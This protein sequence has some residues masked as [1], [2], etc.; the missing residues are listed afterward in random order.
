MTGPISASPAPLPTDGVYWG[1]I[2]HHRFQPRKHLFTYPVFI[3]SVDLDTLAERDRKLRLFGHNRFSL[4]TLRDSDHL[5][6]PE[7]SIKENVTALLRARGYAGPVEKI[8]MV[9]QFRVLGYL[10]NPVTFYYCY[11]GGREVAFVAEVNNTF[12]QRH[13]YVFFGPGR[14]YRT[15]K[16]FYVSP[17]LEMDLVYDFR[18]EPLGGK[19]GVFIDDYKPAAGAAGPEIL[20]LKT[21]IT[22]RHAPLTD[23]ELLLS[24]LRIPY[25]SAWIIGWIHWQALKL[26]LKKVP[27]A[28]RPKN[29]MKPG[30]EA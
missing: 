20:M 9:T 7:L 22:G 3:F 2:V 23:G 5:G 13:C 1:R 14:S 29:G 24:F 8:F 19:L 25:M 17:F 30:W 21:H 15:D 28:F 12:R 26:W 27:L 18:F 10:F 6:D 11:A 4:Y 16:V